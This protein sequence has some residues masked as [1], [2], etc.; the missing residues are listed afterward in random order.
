MSGYQQVEDTTAMPSYLERVV[1]FEQILLEQSTALFSARGDQFD[2]VLQQ[3]LTQIGS[4]LAVDRAY[5]FQF[6]DDQSSMSN[7]HEWCAPGV[8]PSID[9]LQNLPQ[10]VFP[11]WMRKLRQGEEI[12]IGD[13]SALPEEWAAEKETLQMQSICSVLVLPLA[14]DQHLFGFIG[15]DSIQPGTV[16]S[17]ESRNIL[18]FFA[19]N[20]AASWQNELKRQDLLKALQVASQMTS[21]AELASQEKSSFLSNMSHEI[22]TPLN[23]VIGASH[24]LKNMELSK[25]Q[26]RYV[27]IIQSSSQNVL[28]IINSILDLS[29]IEAGKFEINTVPFSLED[30]FG[31][32]HSVFQLQAQEKGLQIEYTI[33]PRMPSFLIGDPLRLQQIMTNLLSNAVKYSAAGKIELQ[34]TLKE[35]SDEKYW[36]NFRVSDQGVGLSAD[37]VSHLFDPFWQASVTTKQTHHGSGLGLAIVKNLCELMG[38]QIEVK[39]EPDVGSEFVLSLPFSLA[40]QANVYQPDLPLNSSEHVLILDDDLSSQRYLAKL[41]HVWS[42]KSVA[43]T[44][45]S[46]VIS[47]VNTPAIQAHPFTLGIIG[48]QH[49]A[50]DGL[51][52]IR[53]LRVRN[54]Q[55]HHVF[56]LAE[57]DQPILANQSS[58]KGL[59]DGFLSK[60]VKASVLSDELMTL[61][62]NN[63]PAAASIKKDEAA[64]AQYRFQNASV[65]VVEDIA[66]NR[67]IIKTLLASFGLSVESA[68]DGLMALERIASQT[69]DLI[70]MDVQM[71]FMDGLEATRKIRALPD[72]PNSRV[73][74]LALT[75]H[76]MQED[77]AACT[78][79]GM[80]DHVIKP[81]DPETLYKCLARWLPHKLSPEHLA[82]P[83][84]GQKNSARREQTRA[85]TTLSLAEQDLF[86]PQIG[87]D[88][89]GG[90]VEIY[91]SLLRNFIA[92]YSD[93][94]NQIEKL[95]KAG[96]R[97]GLSRICHNLKSTTGHAGSSVLS[98]Q[99]HQLNQTIKTGAWPPLENTEQDLVQFGWDVIHLLTVLNHY[100]DGLDQAAKPEKTDELDPTLSALMSR[101]KHLRQALDIHDPLAARQIL[102]QLSKQSLPDQASDKLLRMAKLLNQYQFENAALLLDQTARH[103]FAEYLNYWL[104]SKGENLLTFEEES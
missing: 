84:Q 33:D 46:D 18:Q 83:G 14:A 11:A 35:I 71:P 92:L 2:S 59:I 93:L 48:H 52:L 78:A 19:G 21:K 60:P 28:Q 79:A 37:E 97:S 15:F 62:G 16:W 82:H 91:H 27:E 102:S 76:A 13:V 12:L 73:P 96:D 101:F 89:V 66:I 34:A 95:L 25:A 99:A 85:Q 65:L 10:D 9:L 63:N 80:D 49:A 43:C 40:K 36:I 68:R 24:L 55:L 87:I 1:V 4:Y 56:V 74:I 23:A 94:P 53:Q 44:T 42:I 22:R 45:F 32:L 17:Q 61:L 75:A 88:L 26:G 54:P 31:N 86:D 67:E 64:S 30:V 3:T 57:P 104:D 41:F 70:L 8:E 50:G 77:K 39:S 5:I 103:I 98:A 58:W 100:L 69:F 29:R 7:T 90:N 51:E 38:G 81:I 47:R 72:N 6:D 20:I